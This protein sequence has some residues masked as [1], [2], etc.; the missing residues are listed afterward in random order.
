MRTYRRI[1]FIAAILSL[2][3]F[4]VFSRQIR[5]GFLREADFAFSIKVQ[6]RVDKSAKLRLA[7]AVGEIMEG[8][9]FFASPEFSVIVVSFLTLFSLYAGRRK[10]Y[11]WVG[12]SIPFFFAAL[13]L[14]E[15]YAKNVIHHP[16]PP[17]FMIK[18]PT[19]VFPKYYI[20]ESFSY[21][22]GHAARAVFLGIVLYTISC[23]QQPLFRK[24]AGF[25]MLIIGI[26]FYIFLVSVSRIYL[27]H[28][29]LS[30]IIGGVFLGLGFGLLTLGLNSH[31]I[32]KQ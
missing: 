22:S 20:N 21:P 28:H 10:K 27:G 13:I 30:D 1:I 15:L 26:M 18:N 4:I 31:I 32:D 17:F 3:A 19:T 29:W 23:I 11:Q 24:K 12:L 9:T 6:D 2:L 14:V 7:K 5:T 16:S 8:A 25:I